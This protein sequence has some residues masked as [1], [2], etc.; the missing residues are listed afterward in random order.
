MKPL[1]HISNYFNSRA[2]FKSVVNKELEKLDL[3]KFVLMH[4]FAKCVDHAA[5]HNRVEQKGFKR[6]F[7]KYNAFDNLFREPENVLKFGENLL[8]LK[9]QGYKFYSVPYKR[10]HDEMR[11]FEF[12]ENKAERIKVALKGLEDKP[13]DEISRMHPSF[14]IGDIKEAMEG[15]MNSSQI[16]QLG[17][18]I[19]AWNN[20]ER[21][22][23]ALERASRLAIFL[24]DGARAQDFWQR[25]NSL[26]DVSGFVDDHDTP[27][28]PP[29]S[30]DDKMNVG[31]GISI[32]E[33]R[34]PEWL[35]GEQPA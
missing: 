10:L 23:R 27:P 15:A 19:F 17:S 33:G 30:G 25:V 1:K 3:E 24:G 35:G 28:K 32:P 14:T 11:D 29:G 26:R 22:G 6:L 4:E 13:D 8:K 31:E 21:N 9:I 12:E 2:H 5:M 34:V 16:C 7:A 18:L 20:V